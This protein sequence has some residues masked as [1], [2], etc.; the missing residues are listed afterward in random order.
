M[1]PQLFSLA[2]LQKLRA[3]V[4]AILALGFF[5]ACA[6]PPTLMRYRGFDYRQSYE[7]SIRHSAMIGALWGPRPHSDHSRRRRHANLFSLAW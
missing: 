4:A 5:S 3:S 7:R 1:T 6:T 2:F